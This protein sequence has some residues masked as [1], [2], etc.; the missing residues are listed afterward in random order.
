MYEIIF[1]GL[2]YSLLAKV[3]WILSL[4][5]SATKTDKVAIVFPSGSS[6]IV[7]RY[8]SWRR[9][10]ANLDN[11]YVDGVVRTCDVVVTM[12]EMIRD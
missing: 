4:I 8:L 10:E 5:A 6:S 12:G 2:S 9:L 7:T 11:V 1:Q 3:R